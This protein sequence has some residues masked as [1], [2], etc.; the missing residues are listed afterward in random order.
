L[1]QSA[2][3]LDPKESLIMDG[4]IKGSDWQP[5]RVY[6]PAPHLQA[7]DFYNADSSCLIFNSRAMEVFKGSDILGEFA[8]IFPLTCEG[9]GC[10]EGG[11]FLLNIADC[12]NC[13]DH[14]K[15]IWKDGVMEQM[16]FRPER[17]TWAYKG[18]LFKI[19]ETSRTEIYMRAESNDPYPPAFKDQVDE[20]DL[21]GLYFEEV[22]RGGS[23]EDDES[24]V[25][26]EEEDL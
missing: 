20:Y 2:V 3:P 4:R 10:P 18:Y 13:L 26:T 23:S 5:P 8:E 12:I 7:T 22:W 16:V 6:N 19:P 9:E 14:E 25:F 24:E 11:L 17:S 15:T 21:K 1:Y